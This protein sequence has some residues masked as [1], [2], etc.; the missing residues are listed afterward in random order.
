MYVIL[1]RFPAF[2]KSRNSY[3]TTMYLRFRSVQNA[4]FVFMLMFF[5]GCEEPQEFAAKE[6]LPF[7]SIRA[8]GNATIYLVTGNENRVVSTSMADQLYGVGGKTLSIN[9]GGSM[10]VAVKDLEL[11]WCNACNVGSKDRLVA[12]TLNMYIHAGDVDLY[13]IQIN[14][15][16][17]IQADNTGTYRF[18]GNA[19]DFH[20]RTTNLATVEAF[21]LVTDSTHVYT[22][23]IT[24]ML[25]HATRVLDVSI[26]SSGG[27]VYKGDPAVIRSSGFGNG[28]LQKSN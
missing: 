3:L 9:G 15:R 2:L 11:L 17:S 5:C 13:D 23:S 22:Q 1:L 12:D 10:T 14:G 21:D 8:N 26:G 16:L 25:V 7:N 18:S 20:I 28:Q 24:N 19:N 4:G 6:L 27:V